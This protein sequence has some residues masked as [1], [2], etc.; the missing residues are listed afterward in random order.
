MKRSAGRNV[1]THE[2]LPQKKLPLHVCLQSLCVAKNMQYTKK[3]CWF[4][5]YPD[6]CWYSTQKTKT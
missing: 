1:K 6:H 4:V 2:G 3:N 5:L